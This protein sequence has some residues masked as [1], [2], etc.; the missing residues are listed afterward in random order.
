M[1]LGRKPARHTL[2]TFKSALIMSRALDALGDPPA[3]SNDYT[4]AVTSRASWGMM[5]NDQLGDCVCADTG[6]TLMLRTAN[7]SS[8]IVIPAD[9]DI[10]NL[11][12]AVG[13][14]VPGDESTDNGCDETTMCAYLR[15]TGFLGHTADATGAIEPTNLDHI[16][17][18]IQL[19]GSCRLGVNLPQ[20]A[21]D[22]FN[23]GLPWDVNG[24]STI[25]GG[26]DVPLVKYD[27]NGFW[28]V[29]WGSLQLV[30][31]AFIVKYNEESH[32]ELFFDW[33]QEQGTAPSGLD[34]A[35][36]AAKMASIDT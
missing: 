19:F 34:L 26:H 33:V 31:P 29:T 12:E 7:A 1:K 10:I 8:S 14:Y 3:A 18:C 20:S 9:A 30:T 13:G 21:M 24:D 2:H 36:L 15:T 35:D 25:I 16:K 22:Q 17:W 5:G 23:A 32:S 28:C 27:G 11:Y 4:A 6:H